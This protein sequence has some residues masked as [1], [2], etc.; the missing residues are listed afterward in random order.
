[1]K[2]NHYDYT[3]LYYTKTLFIE[4]ISS[5]WNFL[6]DRDIFTIL[7]FYSRTRLHKIFSKLYEVRN[8]N[9]F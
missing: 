4:N 7:M 1:M 8:I 9:S 3:V 2:K 6:P 5:T